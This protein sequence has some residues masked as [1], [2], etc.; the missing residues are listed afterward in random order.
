M[1][2]L[3]RTVQHSQTNLASLLIFSDFFCCYFQISNSVCAKYR[4][5]GQS[6]GDLLG[7]ELCSLIL[8]SN[9]QHCLLVSTQFCLL[10][11]LENN[12][13]NLETPNK[14]TTESE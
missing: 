11:M 13:Q 6:P 8:Y 5:L 3:V 2:D 4:R 14:P 7:T 12:Q 9:Y 10:D 1:I